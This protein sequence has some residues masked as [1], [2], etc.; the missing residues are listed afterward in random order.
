MKMNV[1]KLY[2]TQI[3]LS[4]WFEKIGHIKT[5]EFRHA[6]NQ[7]RE[8]LEILREE[9]GIMYDKGVKLNLNEPCAL[10][11]I[12]LSPKYP[13]LRIRGKTVAESMQWFAK[14]NINPAHYRA[15]FIPHVSNAIWSTIFVVN[16][17]GIFGEIIKGNH[18]QLTQGFHESGK[19]IAC[20]YDFKTWRM[21]SQND[22]ALQH[23]KDIV[24]LLHVLGTAKQRTI[25]RRLPQ[26]RFVK[27]YLMG[28]FETHTSKEHGLWFADYNTILGEAALP[29][30][31]L[32][33]T[34][35]PTSAGI[36][37]GIVGTEILVCKMTTPQDVP[38]MMKSKGII[39]EMGGILSHAAIV[40]RELKKPC[41][42]NVAGA[43]KKLKKGMMIE[44]NG[45]TGEIKI[46]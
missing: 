39:T 44:M 26:A 28:Y 3:S 33:S 8:Y 20:S 32:S 22:Q 46:L 10:R 30:I 4:E 43:T 17:D 42:T 11:L 35:V 15:E 2:T 45:A 25:K 7:K 41:I 21:S 37:R 23:I 24:K 5:K 40:C 1:G 16:K 34:G 6:D 18:F 29:E 38:L 13:K 19:P 36:A 27:N 14:Q 31:K 9:L 12:P